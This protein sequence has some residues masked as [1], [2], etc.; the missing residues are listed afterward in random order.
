MP[1]GSQGCSR[2]PSRQ[3]ALLDVGLAV[4]ANLLMWALFGVLSAISGA[5]STPVTEV[6]LLTLVIR[7]LPGAFLAVVCIALVHFAASVLKSIAIRWPHV[8]V[9]SM[10]VSGLIKWALTGWDLDQRSLSEVRFACGIDALSATV[11]L[12]LSHRMKKTGRR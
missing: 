6:L 11:G 1:V 10:F 2:E 4:G 12:L 5:T 7:G 3:S 8:L 9:T